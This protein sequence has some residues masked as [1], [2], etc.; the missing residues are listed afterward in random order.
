MLGTLRNLNIVFSMSSHSIPHCKLYPDPGKGK[1]I[2]DCVITTTPIGHVSY[3][4]TP[5]FGRMSHLHQ[6]FFVF[7]V[8]TEQL[9][10]QMC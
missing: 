1:V 7:K 5:D 3:G 10:T 6:L 2:A 9:Q 4:G 8:I